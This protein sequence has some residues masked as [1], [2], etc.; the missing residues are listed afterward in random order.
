M[1]GERLAWKL[2]EEL[3]IPMTSLCPSF[4]IGPLLSG[5]LLEEHDLM[6]LPYSLELIKSWLNGDSPVQSR[7][8]VDV[9]DVAVA[10]V[11][12]ASTGDRIH[13]N[14]H[15]SKY[16]RRRRY[17]V[18]TERRIPAQEVA[19][20]LLKSMEQKQNWQQQQ[21]QQQITNKKKMYCDDKFDGGYIPIGQMEV[22]TSDMLRDEL[23]VTCRPIQESLIDTARQLLIW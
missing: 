7:L 22:L 15:S 1:Y 11:A 10:H 17:L 4:I 19:H 3:V 18:S 9:R 21:Q 13:K 5:S 8:F 16:Y 2:C 12:A 23:S 20:I 14:T 6:S